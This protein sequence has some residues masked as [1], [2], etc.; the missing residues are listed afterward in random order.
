M[1]SRVLLAALAAVLVVCGCKPLGGDSSSGD[2]GG[3]GTGPGTTAPAQLRRDGRWLVD[4]QGR[5]VLIHGVN[6]VWKNPPYYP[7]SSAEGF[8]AADAQWLHDHGFN[9]ARIG[10]LW[11]GVTPHA[12]GEV[13][14]SYL[15]AWDRIIQLMAAKQIWMLFDFH[16]DQMTPEFQGEGFPEWAVPPLKGPVNTILPPPM[17]GF[18]FNY[19]TP[20]VSELYDNL[21][22]ERGMVWDGFRDAWKAVAAKWKNQTYHMGYD[23]MNEPWAGQEFPACIFLYGVGCPS[24][25]SNEIQPF[26]EHA[27]AGI[28]EIDRNN[29]VWMESQLLAGGTG[30]P[31]G[32]GPVAGES[33]LGYSFH[34]Y[35]PL[36]ALFQAA[37]LGLITGS[38]PV[39]TCESFENNV[40]NQARTT[41]ERMGAVELMTEFGASDD[42]A[43]IRRV[44]AGADAHLIGWHYW[45][46]KNWSDPTTQSQASGA[47]GMFA[48]DAD[49]SSV[50]LDKLRL[51]ERTYPQATAG[52]PLEL[53]F[54]PDTAAFNYRY[55][56]RAATAPTQ[57]Y[58][59]VALHYPQ[60]YTVQVTGATVQSAPNAPRLLLANN[61]GATEVTVSVTRP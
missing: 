24:S 35:C 14:Q 54:D 17:F 4:P 30:Y 57:I 18:P 6:T 33:Q 28:R 8:T 37:Q 7:P 11:V 59:P 5:V 58:V 53:S 49:L 23:L 22:A 56:P 39:D 10:T 15:T 9:G 46:Y 12:P 2:S 40:M 26:F 42:L 51:L 55:T 43:L 48:D 34:N 44:T 13:D 27:I 31:T 20:Q 45:H 41:A 52:I 3:P 36:N 25:D 61:P 47:Q 32:L 16:Q 1:R 21:W 29:L 60:G 38:L 50:K 19:F